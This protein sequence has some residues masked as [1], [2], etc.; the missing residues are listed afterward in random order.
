MEGKETAVHREFD[1]VQESV[2][3]VRKGL[4]V[5]IRRRINGGLQAPDRIESEIPD[6]FAKKQSILKD[7]GGCTPREKGVHKQYGGIDEL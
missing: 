7:L 2:A 3:C 6:L 1:Q 4:Y 5:G